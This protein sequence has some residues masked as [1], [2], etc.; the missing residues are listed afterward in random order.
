MEPLSGS[1]APLNVWAEPRNLFFFR[2]GQLSG[3]ESESICEI[4]ALAESGAVVRAQAP[5][6]VGD[7]CTLEVNS[8]H[9]M[10][11]RV[12]W[13]DGTMLGLEL[14]NTREVRDILSRRETSFPYRAP[15][16]KL[17]AEI[18]MSLGAQRV[19]VRCQDISE[20]GMKVE[21]EEA[22]EGANARISLAGVGTLEGQVRWWRD[23]KAGIAFLRPIP[24]ETFTRWVTERLEARAA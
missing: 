6:E 11:A 12:C 22:C 24:S 15:R 13:A 7:A 9:R 20:S 14:T 10:R 21:I 5:L 23:G 19:D 8:A 4:L 3:P 2:T 16:L 17:V 18:Q 1:T